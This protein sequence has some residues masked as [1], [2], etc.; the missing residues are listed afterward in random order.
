ME[1]L[2]TDNPQTNVETMCNYAR[3]K[4]Q[5][6]YLTYADGE[7]VALAEYI[8]KHAAEDHGCDTTAQEVIE[9]DSCME[10]DCPLA[11]LNVVAVQAAELRAR[12][13]KYED[14]GLSPEEINELTHDSTGP[15][16]K[17]LGEWLN[18]EREGRFV[19]LPDNYDRIYASI[20]DNIYAVVDGEVHEYTV[21]GICVNEDGILVIDC[22]EMDICWYEEN[23]Y[24]VEA[25]R[26]IAQYVP[27]SYVGKTV[28]LTREE[29]EAA[30]KGVEHGSNM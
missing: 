7:E 13:M 8:A 21:T 30:L 11:I 23:G 12:L 1:R 17:K 25:E 5:E 29:A 26:P 2:T 9:G 15:L 19:I 3:A 22:F 27:V 16:H 24:P 18:A 10:C 28:F 14:T 20:G 6:V 4:N